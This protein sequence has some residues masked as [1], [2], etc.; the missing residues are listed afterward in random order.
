[1]N[2]LEHFAVAALAWLWHTTLAAG[3]LVAIALVLQAALGR[4][5]TPRWA[6]ALWMLVALRLI[7]PLV[8]E[9]R[10][11]IW[12]IYRST[13]PRPSAALDVPAMP[14][15]PIPTAA[16]PMGQRTTTARPSAPL[17][18]S[19]ILAT[20]WL[21]G[22]M[23]YL[24]LCFTQYRR[25][26]SWV[27][28]QP[29]LCEPRVLAALRSAQQ[30]LGFNRAVPVVRTPHLSAPAVLGI[31]HPCVLLPNGMLETWSDSELRFA[32]LH[33]LVHVRRCDNLLNWGLIVVQALHWFNPL[34]W[35]ALRRIRAEREAL[36][37][38]IVLSRLHPEE[39]H[40]YGAALIKAAESFTAGRFPRAIVPI[41]NHKHEIHRRIH[42]ISLFK[43]T[44]RLLSTAA[45]ALVLTVAC[46]TFTGAAQKQKSKPQ[47][48]PAKP[49]SDAAH[50]DKTLETLEAELQKIEDQV[51]RLEDQL[52][53]MRRDRRIPSH[54]AGG[55]GNQPG[56][57][58]EVLRKL[59]GLR[60]E[61]ATELRR[62]E[63]S[64]DHL[65]GLSRPE[66]RRVIQTAAPDPQLLVFLERLAESEQKYA[67]LSELYAKDHPEVKALSRILQKVSQQ[68]EERLDG[69]LA[70]LKVRRDSLAV[71]EKE[72]RTQI[73]E[74]MQRDLDAPGRYRDF[75]KLKRE[76]ENLYTVRDRLHLRLLEEKIDAALP[77]KSRE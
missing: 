55:N 31:V 46:V 44:S 47:P 20:V 35:F 17:G 57:E 8:P 73:E 39:K 67:S 64:Y 4:W 34:V 66:L 11:S 6:Y 50:R 32:M 71:Q 76:L 62:I 18:F 2:S 33:E 29:P 26:L 48:A 27:R 59:E 49:L 30:V 25:L 45:A 68:I 15:A 23:G 38:A 41:L 3:V 75:F 69:I 22:A 28:R 61:T 58:S 52:Q 77:R 24:I 54:I 43:P 10:F 70:G 16:Q 40:S 53:T 19:I 1:M 5:L 42:M 36:C 65:A 7:V 12:N 13:A 21:A 9:S 56:P 14:E 74:Y 60:I 37:D 72:L 63:T 51:L